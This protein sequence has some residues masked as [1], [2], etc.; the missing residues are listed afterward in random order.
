VECTVTKFRGTRVIILQDI[1]S[2]LA[3]MKELIEQK[4]NHPYLL[5][6]IGAPK[7][8]EDKLLLLLLILNPM[9]L[10]K[11]EMNTYTTSTILIQLA[12]DTHDFVHSTILEDELK[13][14]QL[15]V[16][17]GDYFSGLYYQHLSEIS[18]IS[19]IRE[20][21]KGI[22]EINEHKIMIYEHTPNNDISQL[23]NNLKTIE[24]ALLLKITDYF[25]LSNW[26]EF[27]LNFLLVR[28]L[29]EEK[30]LFINT[31]TSQVFDALKKMNFSKYG[32]EK[33]ELSNEQQQYLLLVC[34]Q[35][36]HHAITMMK[37]GM[38]DLPM[39]N[40]ILNVRISSLLNEHQTKA[41]ILVE[42][43]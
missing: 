43:G 36:I 17:A 21:S 35:I 32:Q 12:L 7:L 38:E 2:R 37:K 6:N 42:E 22:K 28:R 11:I 30:N 3:D 39:E 34:D 25:N 4:A 40:E 15:T 26:N 19:L 10:S 27:I 29:I 31:D 5:Q 20:L 16:L 1:Q 33:I 9:N 14:Q 24:G 18:N 8:D 13:N 23:L 41:N